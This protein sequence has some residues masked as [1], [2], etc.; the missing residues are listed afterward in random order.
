MRMKIVFYFFQSIC[1]LLIAFPLALLPSRFVMWTGQLLGKVGFLFWKSRRNIAI[2]AI[3]KTIDA[4]CLSPTLSP[5]ET[6]K[7]SFVHLGQSFLEL[8][9]VYFTGGKRI[10]ESI[11]IV[12]SEHLYEALDN[13][14]G[15]IIITGHYGNWELLALAF[16][17]KVSKAHA[18]AR[19]QNNPFLNFFVDKIRRRF[20]NTIIY[21]DGALK[22]IM[23]V[24]RSNGIVGILYDQCVVKDEG[25]LVEFLCRKAWTMKI[26]VLLSQKT[27][28]PLL[29]VFI[30]RSPAG[31]HMIMIDKPFYP[32]NETGISENLR[33]MNGFIEKHIKGDPSQWLW[34]HR[35]WKRTDS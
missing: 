8:I 10:I 11:S 13:K 19:R 15:V 2:D 6:A 5:Y 20:G 7:Q 26:P 3:K 17:Q 25:V 35:R 12:G 4:E 33:K 23:S 18:V 34:I 27:G 22:K 14:K 32:A 16:S 28:A 30:R 29:P 21:K 1:I 24:L 9:K 31:G